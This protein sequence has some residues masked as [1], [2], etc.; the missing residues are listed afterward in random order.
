MFKFSPELYVETV[1][2]EVEE[3]DVIEEASETTES[4]NV[5]IQEDSD[6]TSGE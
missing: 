1:T 3:I 4:V 5:S 6:E 2:E